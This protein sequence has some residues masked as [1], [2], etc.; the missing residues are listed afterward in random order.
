MCALSVARSMVACVVHTD[1]LRHVSELDTLILGQ[2]LIVLPADVALRVG[3]GVE[4]GCVVCDD[5][6]G[7][8]R[9]AGEDTESGGELHDGFG[10]RL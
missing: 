8:Q 4:G 6:G 9:E 1:P 3:E 7:E 5:A 2:L 10:R